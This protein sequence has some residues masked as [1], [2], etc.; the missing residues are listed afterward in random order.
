MP[1]ISGPDPTRRSTGRFTVSASGDLLA[2]RPLDG[3]VSVGIVMP[4]LGR[5]VDVSA[6]PGAAVRVL[7]SAAESTE[8]TA[9][10]LESSARRCVTEAAEA[11]SVVLP[12]RHIDLVGLFGAAAFPLL[13]SAYQLGGDPI[14]ELPRWAVPIF[15]HSSIGSASR[16][17]FGAAATRPVRRAMVD[18]LRPLPD[19]TVDLTSLALALMAAPVIQP[20]RLARVLTAARVRQ[21]P[22]FLPDPSTLQASRRVLAEWGPVRV[23]RVMIEAIGRA[24]GLERALETISYAAD[25]GDH[26]P[27]GPLPYRL[28]Q[29]HDVHRALIRTATDQRFAP[30]PRR[31]AP[32]RV[33][34]DSR[35]RNQL[36]ASDQGRDQVRAEPL[37]PEQPRHRMLMA[38]ATEHRARPNAPIRYEGRFLPLDG[39]S[40]GDLELA[41][42]HSVS[43]LT[44]WG[45]LLS[46]CLG[47][48]ASAAVFGRSVIVGV[49]R[50]NL[51]TYAVELTSAGVIR[52][53]CGP[54]NRAPRPVDRRDVIR[55]LADSGALNQGATA[56]REWLADVRQTRD[57]RQAG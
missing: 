52:Q 30:V 22:A 2:L 47:D 37:A 16:T 8:S 48:F 41:L 45:R 50:S 36:A 14:G 5:V 42:P 28:D 34:P 39:A 55:L 19:G 54:A 40:R 21:N 53:F 29:L 20:D 15:Q 26:G 38:P 1:T 43:D 44:R 57:G 27:D 33:T 35:V 23:E 25:L 11:A 18:A 3:R 7:A 56:N 10:Q 12:E 4:P 46:N 9:E 51:L 24:D 31:A 49:R 17:A 6:Q 32:R 13:G